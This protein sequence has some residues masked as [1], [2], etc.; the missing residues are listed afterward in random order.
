MDIRNIKTDAG[1]P[2][3]SFGSGGGDK[4]RMASYTS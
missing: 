1:N 4:Y 3:A 2:Q